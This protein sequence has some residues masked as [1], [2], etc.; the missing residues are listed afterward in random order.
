MNEDQIIAQ[1]FKLLREGIVAGD[2][3]RVCDS[4]ELVSGEKLDPPNQKPKSR[5]ESIRE[6]ILSDV[7]AATEEPQQKIVDATKL[8]M[9]ELK[10]ALLKRGF[11]PDRLKGKKKDQLMELLNKP[12]GYEPV[13][14]GSAVQE[15]Q[16]GN[17]FGQGKIKVIS[18][19]YDPLEASL[20][21]KLKIH[22]DTRMPTTE[23]PSD[24]DA[25]FR[26]NT[27]P[28]MPPWR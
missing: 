19:P 12:I 28:P 20:N 23:K 25:D 10:E 3:Q 17:R 21:A 2:W 5:L 7:P 8:S 27:K 6:M 9:N 15:F 13:S 18:D 4:Y 22:K 16:G 24:P 26:L 1:G 11:G 14:Q